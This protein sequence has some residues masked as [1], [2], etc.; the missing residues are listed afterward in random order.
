MAL[1]LI[2]GKRF[3]EHLLGVPVVLRFLH[4]RRLRLRGR[5]ETPVAK[6][7]RASALGVEAA[8]RLPAADRFGD[9]A[10]LRSATADRRRCK[11]VA[12]ADLSADRQVGRKPLSLQR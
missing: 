12:Q 8:I 5:V 3:E 2:L 6:T 9:C 7:E 10:S 11:T 4:E 1:A